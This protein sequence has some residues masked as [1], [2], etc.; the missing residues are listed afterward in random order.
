MR[1]NSY[2][3]FLLFI[4]VVCKSFNWSLRPRGRPIQNMCYIEDISRKLQ[5]QGYNHFTSY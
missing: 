5:E 4:R 2:E 1:F 3:N